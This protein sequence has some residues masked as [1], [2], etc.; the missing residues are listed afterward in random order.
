MAL[1]YMVERLRGW[2]AAA[3]GGESRPDV[4][5][6]AG[7]T[8]QVLQQAVDAVVTIDEANCVTFFNPAAEELWGYARDEVIGRNVK[9]LVPQ[10]LRVDHDGFVN[11]NRRTRIDKIVGTS[12]QVQIERRDGKR[13]WVNL[14][15]SRIAVGEAIHYTAFVSD[16]SAQR[17]AEEITHQTLEQALDA[18]VTIDTRNHVTFFNSAA[19]ALWGYSRDDVVGQN[20]KMLVPD[21][22]RG[23]HDDLVNAN[24]TT[25]QDRI[26]GTNREV[27]IQRF[28]GSRCWASLS[29]SKVELEDEIIYTAFVKD[30]SEQRRARS[31]MRQTLEQALDAVVSIDEHNSVTFFN[32][33]AERL[34][35]YSRDE[36][37]GRN[38]RMLVPQELQANHDSFVDANRTSGVDKIVGTAREVEVYR[39]DGS[40]RWG[41]LSLSKIEIDGA[42]TYTAFV[43]D[44]TAEVENRKRMRTLSLVA[45]ETGN[46]VIIT[47]ARGVI[48]YVN[49]GFTSMTGY[50]PDEAIGRR[51]GDILQGELTDPAT[52]QRIRE[53]LEVHKPFYEEILNYHKDGTSYWISLSVNPI[54]APN[55]QLERFISIQANITD[56]K[57]AALE[58][59][60]RLEAIGRSNAVLEWDPAGSFVSC[61]EVAREILSTT[62]QATP[63][64]HEL[65][66]EREC[67]EIHGGG[68]VTKIVELGGL[69]GGTV[70]VSGTLQGIA[71]YEGVLERIVFYGKDISDRQKLVKGS[72]DTMRAVL[73]RINGMAGG[74]SGI[75]KQTKLLSLNATIEAAS[76]GDAGR[77][78]AVVA[79]EVGALASNTS[80]L[81][82]EIAE[83][84]DDTRSQIRALDDAI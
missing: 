70:F 12:R 43:Q 42:V 69:D 18:V 79:N 84:V 38:V 31:A 9:M 62:R 59:T 21:E 2:A 44:V 19:E 35:G 26:V 28:D 36:V 75:A 37:E 71:N 23:N 29:L 34:W 8:D 16:V 82:Q 6:V 81:A 56:T 61:N 47:D 63:S 7:A 25:G 4:E 14:S 41:K 55:G 58:F 50:S 72:S 22:I 65:A 78:F 80:E 83:L 10:E 68:F 53:R 11:A 32:K 66:D 39:K 33:A 67:A 54:F 45:D 24:R 27:E 17:R 20:V 73:D 46:S 60:A 1:K 51:P 49:P 13:P 64:L 74:I 76:A 40:M 77:G 52:V 15:L 5:A 30:I 3:P 48:E 57:M